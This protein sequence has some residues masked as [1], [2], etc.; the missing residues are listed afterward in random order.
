MKIAFCLE[1]GNIIG[2]EIWQHY[3][4]FTKPNFAE[5]FGNLKLYKTKKYNKATFL[6]KFELFEFLIA[7]NE[8]CIKIRQ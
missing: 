6:S 7:K 2:L 1:C 4:P 5:S 8:N 3:A